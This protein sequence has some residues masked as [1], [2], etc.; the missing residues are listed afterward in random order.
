MKTI[1]DGNAIAVVR[2]DF[3]NLQESASVWF[4]LDHRIGKILA[5]KG[6][7]ELPIIDLKR[8]RMELQE[9]TE[10]II[11]RYYY[12]KMSHDNRAWLLYREGKFCVYT[13]KEMANRVRS[14]LAMA[15]GFV[16]DF[17]VVQMTVSEL[18]KTVGMPYEIFDVRAGVFKAQ[19]VIIPGGEICHE[20]KSSK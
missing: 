18:K 15:S 2:D 3:V 1:I 17:D 19:G 9:Q 8:I 7:S 5:E 13:T 6:L 14:N 12:I 11:N 10:H 20:S 4:D 16:I